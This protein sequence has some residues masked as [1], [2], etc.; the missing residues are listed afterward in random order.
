MRIVLALKKLPFEYSA[1]D[2][3]KNAG[4]QNQPAYRSVNPQGRVPSLEVE[5]RIVTQSLAILEYLDEMHPEPPLLPADVLGRAR[6]RSLADIVAC[7][8]QP[9]Q[10]L[11]VT[12]YLRDR[13]GLDDG[14]V[15]AWLREWI[16]RGLE[17]L[18]TRLAR[19]PET[20]RFFCHG[21]Q[22]TMAD[23]C[24]VPQCY[25]AERFGVD[26]TRYPTVGRINEACRGLEAFK[27][28]APAAQP[29][30]QR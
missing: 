23:A 3:V 1:V 13:L 27:A 11:C 19:E 16:G 9:L 15:K 30:A 25:A 21:D 22:P 12:A 26:F 8:I 10:N 17:A 6:V 18:E 20:G 7:D 4:E 2:L 29:D 5:G 28:A 14:A 24:L